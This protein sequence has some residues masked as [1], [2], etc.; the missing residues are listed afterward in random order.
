M[1]GGEAAHGVRFTVQG[2]G[3]EKQMSDD[4]GRRTE[5]RGQRA[6]VRRRRAEEADDQD[7]RVLMGGENL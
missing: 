7:G 1:T 2:L 4:G 5:D 3:A 6:D